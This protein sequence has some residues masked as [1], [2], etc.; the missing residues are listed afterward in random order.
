MR[1]PLGYIRRQCRTLATGGIPGVRYVKNDLEVRVRRSI[2]RQRFIRRRFDGFQMDLYTR[3]AGIS[4]TLAI[5][6][7]REE[8][9]MHIIQTEITPGARVL[10]IG[11]NI[12]F[13]ALLEATLVGEHGKVYA[14]EPAPSNFQLLERNIE[15]N[16]FGT[17]ILAEPIAVSNITGQQTFHIHRK[18][19]LHTLNPIKYHEGK[20]DQYS[21]AI[22]VHTVAMGDLARKWPDIQFIRM[23]IEGHEV[24]VLESMIP[25][26]RSGFS[27]K[28][29]F[30]CHFPKYSDR[31]H[32]LRKP[33]SDL[34]S[35][36]YRV[37]I[38]AS[39]GMSEKG[40]SDRGYAPYMVIPSSGRDHCLY[41]DVSPDD[42]KTIICD[43][44]RVRA[45]LLERGS[46]VDAA[47]AEHRVGR[48]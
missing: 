34:F 18:S 2:F 47:P 40:F 48:R 15:L 33:L 9:Q 44:G 38:M 32:S 37:K 16:G 30:E 14:V 46:Q 25:A 23:D 31:V 19:N 41:R 17:R 43:I 6:G 28:V 8:D 35:L 11:A 1:K 20:P 36:G 39:N 5:Y 24:E 10:D 27:P 3:D 4:G 7:K 13:Y 12:G 42:A 26:V 21:T 45:V 22:Q 29:M